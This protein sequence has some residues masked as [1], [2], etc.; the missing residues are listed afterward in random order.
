MAFEI[1]RKSRLNQKDFKGLK[2]FK[3]DYPMAK[4]YMLYGGKLRLQENDCIILPIQEVFSDL[5][6]ILSKD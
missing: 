6:R 1:K 2:A 3:Q 4:C 5:P